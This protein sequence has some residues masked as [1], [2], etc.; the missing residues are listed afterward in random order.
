M[1]P[2]CTSYTV[3]TQNGSYCYDST[4]EVIYPRERHFIKLIQAHGKRALHPQVHTLI[5]A[6]PLFRQHDD[7]G[8]VYPDP[9]RHLAC[10][11]LQDSVHKRRVVLCKNT[12]MQP[13][14]AGWY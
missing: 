9:V 3:V 14:S 12:K 2:L 5:S 8:V 13:L 11:V 7:C 6:C 10:S 4:S 1:T